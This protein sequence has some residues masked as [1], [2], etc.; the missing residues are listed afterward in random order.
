MTIVSPI[1]VGPEPGIAYSRRSSLATMARIVR[2]PLDA[3]PPEVFDHRLVVSRIFGRDRVYVTDPVLIHEA[4]VRNADALD[5]GQEIK[6]V[7]GPAIGEGLLTADGAHW[8]WQRQSMAPA[9]QHGRLLGLLPAMIVAAEQ[10]RDR[11]RAAKPG[12]RFDVGHDMMVTTF[13]IIVDTMLSGPGQIDAGRV[14]RSVTD[15][16]QSTNWMFA[17]ALLKAPDWMPYP[18]RK[19][20]EAAAA[21]MR[22]AVLTMIADRRREAGAQDDLVALLLAAADPETGRQMTDAEVADN[23][24]TFITAGHETTAV[25]LGW[26][27]MLLA[28][29]PAIERRVV[30]EI[31][32]ITAGAP[33]APEHI[34]ALAYTRQVFQEAMRLYPPA[35]MIARRVLKPFAL[36]GVT[37]EADTM[38]TVPIYALHRHAAIWD[39]PDTFDPDRFAPEPTKARHRYAFMPFGAGA[40]ICIGSAFATMEA[41]AILAVLLQTVRLEAAGPMPKALMKVTLRPAET[42]LMRVTPRL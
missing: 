4:L 33:I 20:T 1:T 13:K 8:R 21:Y 6:R 24:L 14:E 40:R 5:K 25:A 37:I 3:F 29:H 10:T 39:D 7:L 19:R 26:T 28:K 17:L 31:S 23:L 38:L 2:N 18:G 22:D 9:F 35:P 42:V 15:Y 12:T 16:L 11:W 36:A 30:D 41:V 34:E 27:F 32:A